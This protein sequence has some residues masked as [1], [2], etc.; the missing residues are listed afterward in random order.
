MI[1]KETIVEIANDYLAG[2]DFV[3]S[4]SGGG[5][6]TPCGWSVSIIDDIPGNIHTIFIHDD[7]DADS[8]SS[9]LNHFAIE[10]LNPS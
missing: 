5:W 7:H 8:V 3:V 9:K 2:H 4:R 10:A 6:P 1:T